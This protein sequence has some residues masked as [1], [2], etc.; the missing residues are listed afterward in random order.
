VSREL[1]SVACRAR[2]ELSNALCSK[3][4][5]AGSR[6]Q[7]ARSALKAA[8]EAALRSRR[9]GLGL[10]EALARRALGQ[11]LALMGNWAHADG[12]FR[13]AAAIQERQGAAVELIVTRVAASRAEYVYAASPR[14]PQLRAQLTDARRA[15][16]RIGFQHE[17]EEAA[18]LLAALHD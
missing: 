11:V 16:E 6:D 1:E 15:A 8:H 4:D 13:A 7:V 18:R 9:L 17:R 2:V 12:E 3:I 5:A 10:H 14:L